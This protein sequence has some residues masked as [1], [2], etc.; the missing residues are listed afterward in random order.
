M[1]VSKKEY[2]RKSIEGLIQRLEELRVSTTIV[3]AWPQPG[4]RNLSIL[5]DTLNR[6]IDQLIKHC[7]SAYLQ[8]IDILA[9]FPYIDSRIRELF[10]FTLFLRKFRELLLPP[11]T[12]PLNQ[13]FTLTED[14][15][16]TFPTQTNLA[17]NVVFVLAPTG[18][19]STSPFRHLLARGLRG[20]GIPDEGGMDTDIFCLECV[21]NLRLDRSAVLAHEVFHVL[22]FKNMD[23]VIPYLEQVARVSSIRD[24]Y[25]M[26]EQATSRGLDRV[27]HLTEFFCDYGA[28]RHVG[29]VYARSFIAEI[30]YYPRTLTRSHPPSPLRAKLISRAL[31]QRTPRGVRDFYHHEKGRLQADLGL[32]L[33]LAER[34][35]TDIAK[36]F[37]A[38]LESDF[39]I[40]LFATS[41]D[42][43]PTKDTLAHYI[44]HNL[45]Y[46]YE[47]V[48]VFLNALPEWDQISKALSKQ[49]VSGQLQR[50]RF[51][52]FLDESVLCSNA[53]RIF[54]D[55]AKRAQD[56]TLPLPKAF[57]WESPG[58][59]SKKGK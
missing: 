52:D 24:M 39:G 10:H 27:G 3:L 31:G 18:S 2:C 9:R 6:T 56:V 57:R 34:A 51:A 59:A 5:R 40:K 41:Q 37:H 54:R 55:A 58:G 30:D 26:L 17:R 49:G 1:T 8:R 42:G 53:F 36:R 4:A 23:V 43:G 32:D 29:P 12:F 38:F 19:F 33:G 35:L 20:V 47:D 14:M 11:F 22:V 13:L 28:A 15:L 48:R 46:I 7:K 45:P 44:W 25:D 21:S 16:R 50:D